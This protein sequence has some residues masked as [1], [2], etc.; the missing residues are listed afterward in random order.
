MS[1]SEQLQF[2]LQI[3]FPIPRAKHAKAFS[4]VRIV[5]ERTKVVW[6]NDPFTWSVENFCARVDFCNDIFEGKIDFCAERLGHGKQRG[7]KI[8]LDSLFKISGVTYLSIHLGVLLNEEWV[9][10][11]WNEMFAFVRSSNFIFSRL[12]SL[13][14]C[15]LGREL[16]N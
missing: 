15:Q 9:L 10:L 13:P 8:A 5:T 14:R 11:F 16:L 6:N 4:N 12:T 2:S 7:W 3:Y 1:S